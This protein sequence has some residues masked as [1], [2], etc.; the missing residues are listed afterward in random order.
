MKRGWFPS[1]NRSLIC[2]PPPLSEKTNVRLTRGTRVGSVALVLGSYW[3]ARLIKNGR[4]AAGERLDR[5]L[6]GLVP[7][8]FVVATGLTYLI[9]ARG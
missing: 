9:Y 4:A 1:K 5:R 6:A 8:A 2:Q 3:S 7:G